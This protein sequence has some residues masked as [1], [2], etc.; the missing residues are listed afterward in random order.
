MMAYDQE[1]KLRVVFLGLFCKQPQISSDVWLFYLLS[2]P[3]YK[4]CFLGSWIPLAYS[5][6]TTCRLWLI[7]TGKARRVLTESRW[8][9]CHLQFPCVSSPVPFHTSLALNQLKIQQPCRL[10]P[11]VYSQLGSDTSS[12]VSQHSFTLKAPVQRAVWPQSSWVECKHTQSPTAPFPKTTTGN[13]LDF[14]ILTGCLVREQTGSEKAKRWLKE[15]DRKSKKSDYKWKLR[16]RSHLHSSTL[17]IPRLYLQKCCFAVPVLYC[18][19]K[20]LLSS[21]SAQ[22]GARVK[23]HLGNTDN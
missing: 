13:L 7:H 18:K 16:K 21:C 10:K 5:I 23:G 1:Y 17:K 9:C 11:S 6:L 12:H 4:P 8:E 15:G 22:G 20:F 19:H 3:Q 2:Y 14:T